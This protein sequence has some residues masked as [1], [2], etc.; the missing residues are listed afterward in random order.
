MTS[1]NSG[2]TTRTTS[3]VQGDIELDNGLPENRC[4]DGEDDLD[5]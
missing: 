5:W 4:E 1:S 2:F 3:P